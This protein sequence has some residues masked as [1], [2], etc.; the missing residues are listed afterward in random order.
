M[1]VPG[2][3]RWIRELPTRWAM[4][5]RRSQMRERRVRW[6]WLLPLLVILSAGFSDAGQARA[7]QS[8]AYATRALALR[9]KESTQGTV[10]GLVPAGGLVTIVRCDSVWCLVRYGSKQGVVAA[11]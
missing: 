7:P 2:R 10:R 1:R 5:K 3:G 11:Q 4:R 6:A 9:A 8:R